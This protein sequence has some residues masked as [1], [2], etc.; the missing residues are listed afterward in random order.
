MYAPAL[1]PRSHARPE[2][3]Q[4]QYPTG[5]GPH[6]PFSTYDDDDGGAGW[7]HD[8]R[9]VEYARADGREWRP[10]GTAGH[11]ASSKATARAAAIP[12]GRRA[13]EEAVQAELG[14]IPDIDRLYVQK[15]PYER[16]EQRAT[17]KKHCSDDCVDLYR[18]F[19]KQREREGGLAKTETQVRK[20]NKRM[21]EELKFQ[22][23]DPASKVAYLVDR[24]NLNLEP[25]PRGGNHEPHH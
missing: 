23:M 24:A 8:E 10:N 18:N 17:V 7:W 25:R 22:Q 3:P 5:V 12:S 6:T 9:E 14:S 13:T 21:A 19:R 1:P 16:F 4:Q 15:T 11:V 20:Q 2:S